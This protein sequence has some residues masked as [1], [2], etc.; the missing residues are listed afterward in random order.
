MPIAQNNVRRDD[1]GISSRNTRPHATLSQQL[2]RG[3]AAGFVATQTL[4]ILSMFFYENLPPSERLEEDRTRSGHQAYEVMVMKI[5]ERIGV[6][7]SESEIKYWGWKFHRAFGVAGG[8]QYMMLR[9]KF[10]TV[11]KAYGFIFGVAFFAIADEVLIY[12][13]N[14]TPGPRNFGWKSHARGAVAHIAFGVACELVA[15]SFEKVAEYEAGIGW[16]LAEDLGRPS[17]AVARAR[18]SRH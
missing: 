5:A 6:P 7:L 3:V 17:R 4:D 8:V 15:L 16:A 12:L 11:K 13:V 1:A 14:A 10:P 9:E 18:F 2:V